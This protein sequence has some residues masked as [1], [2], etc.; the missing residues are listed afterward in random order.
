MG[1][2]D[3]TDIMPMPA[4]QEI[5]PKGLLEAISF[6]EQNF[7]NELGGAILKD[8]FLTTKQRLEFFEVGFRSSFLSGLISALLTPVAIGVVE[9]YI[10]IFGDADPSRFDMAFAFLL[11]VGYSLGFGI[12]LAYACTK[13]VGGYTRS[14]I[15]NLL[16]GVVAGSVLKAILAFLGFH[17]IYFVLLSDANMQ[18]G[19]Q[20]LYR[21][22]IPR[23]AVVTAYSWL[24][25]FKPVFLTSA[26][27]IVGVTVVF[28]AIPTI[29]MLLARIRNRKLIK[30]GLVHV[31]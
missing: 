11:A 12:F 17:F 4:G 18:K 10:P 29:S 30:A 22:R 5:H 24:Y 15:R 6:I 1:K 21:A 26:W 3:S 7:S 23:N 27:F 25:D 14:M 28:I 31:E 9:R 8:T 20:L 16:G 13:F 2:D 19:A